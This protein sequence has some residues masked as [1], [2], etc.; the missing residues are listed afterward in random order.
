MPVHAGKFHDHI[1]LAGDVERRDR[2]P[3]PVERRQQLP[4]A[5]D[6]AIP[7]EPA[8]KPGAGE[9][10]GVEI[11]VG[12]GEPRGQR[13]RLEVPARWVCAAAPPCRKAA[14]RAARRRRSRSRA[15]RK[16]VRT[17]RSYSASAT[18]GSWRYSWY[19]IASSVCGI[20]RRR[21]ALPRA[22]NGTLRPMTA[23][24]RSGRSCAACHATGAP[25][26]WPTMTA[27]SAPSASTGPA[28]RRPCGERV[29]VDR[30]GAV[31]PAIAAHVGRHGVE[32][33]FGQRHE[34]MPPRIPK[35]RK[36]VAQQDERTLALLGQV[37]ADAVGLDRA[38]PQ[39]GHRGQTGVSPF[40]I[41]R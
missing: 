11:D 36:A 33:S 20:T 27:L 21:S 26:S 15:A 23:R 22:R 34:L 38:V 28:C 19:Q 13:R 8:A 14:C 31:R 25:Q 4:V 3:K 1:A 2:H 35:L 41:R 16:I 18:P 30:L 29:L 17:L 7:V 9:F 39:P 37:H 12:L 10:R 40:N 32:P 6:V 5:V 24:K